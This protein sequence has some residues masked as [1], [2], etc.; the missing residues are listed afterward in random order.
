MKTR[1]IGDAEGPKN[2]VE[3]FNRRVDMQSDKDN[4]KMTEQNRQMQQVRQRMQNSLG[5]HKIETLKHRGQR[6]PNVNTYLLVVLGTLA[7]A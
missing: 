2:V 4:S 1:C 6:G 5:V 7:I 3:A